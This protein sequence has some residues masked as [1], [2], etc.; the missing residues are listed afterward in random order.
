M[1]YSAFICT[2]WVTF[3]ASIWILYVCWFVA[4]P[5]TEL[6]HLV[7][8]VSTS[9]LLTPIVFPLNVPPLTFLVLFYLS[10]L[11]YVWIPCHFNAVY[12]TISILLSSGFPVEGLIQQQ[13][14]YFVFVVMKSLPSKKQLAHLVV[15]KAHFLCICASCLKCKVSENYV[16]E[17]Q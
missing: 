11:V 5:A 13:N 1:F 17:Y 14:G 7:L 8:S 12:G 2:T 4:C 3:A 6:L 10:C 15:F 9:S 16:L